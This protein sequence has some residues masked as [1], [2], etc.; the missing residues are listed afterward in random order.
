MTSGKT[1]HLKTFECIS[2]TW[3][4]MHLPELIL[5]EVLVFSRAL[6]GFQAALLRDVSILVASLIAFSNSN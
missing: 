2:G 1:V 6:R 5:R 3:A 4:L